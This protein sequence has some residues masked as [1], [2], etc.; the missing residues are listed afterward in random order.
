MKKIMN[1]FLLMW[2][3]VLIGGCDSK[4]DVTPE[5]LSSSSLE[6]SEEISFLAVGRQGY[7]NEPVKKIAESMNRI[8][9]E[10]PTD[11]VV[12]AG[13]HFY[14][15]GVKSVRDKRW[16]KDFEE[17]YSGEHLQNLPFYAVAGNHD[18]YG[19]VVPQIKYS[20][21]KLGS[22]R[23]RM[24]Y[25]FY[26]ID[27]GGVN[28]RVLARMVFLD[29]ILMEKNPDRQVQFLKDEMRKPGDPIWKIIVN[30]YPIRS[31]THNGLAKTR[32]LNEL[33][34]IAKDLDV[35]LY[36]SANDPFQQ[37]LQREGE[38]LHLGTNGGG[39]FIDSGIKLENSEAN[40]I[41]LQRGFGR[42]AVDN[43]TMTVELRDINGRLSYQKRI[44]RQP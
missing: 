2:L 13:D 30:H 21:D 10:Y 29:A 31:M 36:I 39:R 8:A 19:T 42:V 24:P 17:L 34:P 43:Q 27:F 4:I 26:A 16:T 41:F 40:I 35:D 12:Q 25:Y 3:L 11:F 23:W 5:Q 32:I 1:L 14:P 38:P 6:T 33:L 22:G 44:Q 37:L 15:S 28:G 7:G 18:H 20:Q 9:G